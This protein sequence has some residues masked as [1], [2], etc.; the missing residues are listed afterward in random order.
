MG[1]GKYDQVNNILTNDF[2][3]S[4]FWNKPIITC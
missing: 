4:I 2:E 3:S 1:N